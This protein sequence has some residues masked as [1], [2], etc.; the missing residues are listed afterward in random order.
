[1]KIP[2]TP[3]IDLPD[4]TD[5]LQHYSVP[6]GYFE[7]LPDRI[8]SRIPFD[9]TPSVS[10]RGSRRPMWQTFRPWLSIA[11]ALIG[12]VGLLFAFNILGTDHSILT[13]AESDLTESKLADAEFEEYIYDQYS[14]MLAA[15]DWNMTAD[16]DIED[17][18]LW[19]NF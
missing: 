7:H 6:E 12:V 14:T 18:L 11:A 19:N 1:M 16:T 8:L 13:T 2:E 17:P 3:Q 15:E 4:L 9:E 10:S 5:R